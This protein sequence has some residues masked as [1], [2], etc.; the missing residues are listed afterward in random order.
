MRG[1]GESNIFMR[2]R[3]LVVVLVAVLALGACGDDDGDQTQSTEDLSEA[4]DD[5]LTPE[6]QQQ[7]CAALRTL[8]AQPAGQQV[9]NM[10]DGR[11]DAEAAASVLEDKC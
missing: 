6:Q 8:G 4:W 9:A 1:R 3:R 7:A 2:A 10:T 5:R 11:V